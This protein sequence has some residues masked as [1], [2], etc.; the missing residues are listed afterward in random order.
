MLA[1]EIANLVQK[2]ANLLLLGC[3]DVRH[4]LFTIHTEQQARDPRSLD[5][6]CCDVD[7]AVIARNIVLLS[8]V[9]DDVDGTNEQ[10]IWNLFYHFRIDEGS[11]DLLQTHIPKLLSLS[12]SL[13]A[14]QESQYGRVIRICDRVSL[15]RV[16]D[17]WR[18]YGEKREGDVLRHFKKKLDDGMRISQEYQKSVL[19]ETVNVITG[20]RAAAPA[21][22]ETTRDL[23]DLYKNYW[24]FGDRD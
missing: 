4:I 19:G 17:M 12:T 9:L 11:L 8:L 18:F 23:S 5:A 16:R 20:I 24:G 10:L 22:L 7:T 13:Q 14:W 15:E 3:G 2:K 6:T 21:C 1:P